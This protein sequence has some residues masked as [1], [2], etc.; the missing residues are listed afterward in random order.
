[1]HTRRP[2]PT[3]QA[4]HQQQERARK[5]SQVSRGNTGEGPGAGRAGGGGAR[6]GRPGRRRR[7]SPG[8]L[9]S[10][11]RPPP[12]AARGRRDAGSAAL[13]GRGGFCS[14]RHR[15][16]RVPG[17]RRRRARRCPQRSGQTRR[18]SRAGGRRGAALP[19]AAALRGSPLRRDSRQGSAGAHRRRSR[20]GAE[21]RAAERGSA[22]SQPSVRVPAGPG[23]R[24][25]PA[26][27]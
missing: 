23:E 21:C 16:R 15:G 4:R 18:W 26:Q 14:P 9:G 17:L 25:G 10:P 11:H 3:S 2:G 24:G 27:T 20:R 8:L 7:G 6:T 1:M 5:Y 19:R 22:G 12:R 13:C